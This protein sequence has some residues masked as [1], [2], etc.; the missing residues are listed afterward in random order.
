MGTSEQTTMAA[1]LV[2]CFN[3]NNTLGGAHLAPQCPAIAAQSQNVTANHN[4]GAFA[5]PNIN[6]IALTAAANALVQPVIQTLGQ[7]AGNLAPANIA[8][9]DQATVDAL[10]A[11]AINGTITHV[12]F[13][14]EMGRRIA[15][16]PAGSAADT[17]AINKLMTLSTW[18]A[19]LSSSIT[20]TIVKP[21]SVESL[22]KK[23]FLVRVLN[24]CYRFFS[25]KEKE[26]NFAAG[27]PVTLNRD[28]NGVIVHASTE[29][30]AEGLGQ[31]RHTLV[32]AVWEEFCHIVRGSGVCTEIA[33][34]TFL[35]YHLKLIFAGVDLT[36]VE[37]LF[38]I[39]L[40]TIDDGS[41]TWSTVLHLQAPQQLAFLKERQQNSDS[42]GQGSEG[43]SSS[44]IPTGTTIVRQ[45]SREGIK[46]GALCKAYNAYGTAGKSHD[47]LSSPCSQTHL[48]SARLG[49]GY[50]CGADHPSW[51]HAI[52]VTPPKGQP[53]RSES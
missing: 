44:G 14:A 6:S 37:R 49:N 40:A 25:Q 11:Q 51:M 47:C 52:K 32:M 50:I 41:T 35:T 39:L 28:L 2:V 43:S 27:T 1:A 26:D 53:R 36:L 46:Y 10:Q 21:L 15:T 5:A 31:G 18:S 29:Q 3:C 23:G 13:Q 19:N 16:A 8:G 9:L 22:F 48:C 20:P 12:T 33:L 38:S 7:A 17:H 42:T 34:H 4:M 30:V 24:S 45:T